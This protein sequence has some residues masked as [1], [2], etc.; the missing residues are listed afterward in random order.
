MQATTNI[1]TKFVGQGGADT[2]PVYR[3]DE[4]GRSTLGYIKRVFA[5]VYYVAHDGAPYRDNRRYRS[6]DAALAALQQ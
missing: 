6:W 5:D 3:I 4:D 1:G 2:F